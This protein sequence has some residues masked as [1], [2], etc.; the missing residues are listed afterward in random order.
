M[1]F[2]FAFNAVQT[3]WA[4]TFAALLVLLV[5][6]LGKDRARR[7]PVFTFAVALV[8]FRLLAS[9]MLFGR[10]AMVPANITFL[11]LALVAGLTNVAVV[12]ELAWKSFAGASRKAWLISTLVMLAI[13]GTMVALWGPWPALQTLRGE[14]LISFFRA[15]QLVAQRSDML[16]DALAIE[17]GVLVLIAG[18]KFNAGWKSHPLRLTVGFALAALSQLAV[19][20]TWQAIATH[21]VPHSQ[22][23]Y[24]HLL[25]LQEKLYNGNSIVYLLVLVA[26]IVFLWLDEPGTVAANIEPATASAELPASSEEPTEN[27]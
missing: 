14:G 11:I 1:H 26:W 5:V 2:N 24:E 3:L 10:M 21:A 17:L 20:G 9:R 19:R 4:L 6:L 23:E 13:G 25:G 18:R 22:E 12:V 15:I 8:A 27:K 16:A 7:F